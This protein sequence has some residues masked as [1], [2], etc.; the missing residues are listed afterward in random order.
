M[1]I[2]TVYIVCIYIYTVYIYIYIHT[3]ICVYIYICR[4]IENQLSMVKHQ[5][6]QKHTISLKTL[7]FLETR[8]DQFRTASRGF[9]R[10]KL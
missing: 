2:Y 6:H 3:M 5:K 9:E 4:D 7:R 8:K 10:G 1:Y